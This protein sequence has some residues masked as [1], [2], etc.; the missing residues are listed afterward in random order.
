M[1]SFAQQSLP[2]QVRTLGQAYRFQRH[3]PK[4]AR[5]ALHCLLPWR[6]S[7]RQEPLETGQGFAPHDEL[8]YR[9]RL[10]MTWEDV[11]WWLDRLPADSPYWA[12]LTRHWESILAREVTPNWDASLDAEFVLLQQNLAEWEAAFDRINFI[13][14]LIQC[15]REQGWSIERLQQEM[16]SAVV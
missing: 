13:E 9:L 16:A 3:V 5:L 11:L 12:W 1:T 4:L 7:V 2:H 6:H 8:Y 15:A 10:C 14:S